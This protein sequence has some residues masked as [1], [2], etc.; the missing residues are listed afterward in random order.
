MSEL[1]KLQA[2]QREMGFDTPIDTL[3]VFVVM[4][5][6]TNGMQNIST[7]RNLCALYPDAFMVVQTGDYGSIEFRHPITGQ[8]QAR[9]DSVSVPTIDLWTKTT[10]NPPACQRTGTRVTL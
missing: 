10:K 7:L 8:V 5:S 2:Y 6:A 1:D 3:P 9:F 4:L